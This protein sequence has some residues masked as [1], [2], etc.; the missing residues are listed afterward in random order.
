MPTIISF[1]I[2]YI[3]SIIAATVDAFMVSWHDPSYKTVNDGQK[4][5]FNMVQEDV[6][7]GY[8]I[9]TGETE[10]EECKVILLMLINF[11][12]MYR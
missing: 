6:H 1:F 3:L 11:I 2:S 12:N 9:A 8:D 7:N 10:C 4:M 5:F